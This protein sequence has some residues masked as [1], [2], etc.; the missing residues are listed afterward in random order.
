VP[1]VLGSSGPGLLLTPSLSHTAACLCRVYQAP[2]KEHA[3][4]QGTTACV[5]GGCDRVQLRGVVADKMAFAVLCDM[6]CVICEPSF[7]A[8]TVVTTSTALLRAASNRASLYCSYCCSSA[9]AAV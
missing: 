9:W 4:L 7:M 8:H 1:F 5:C 2:L 6:A 3:T